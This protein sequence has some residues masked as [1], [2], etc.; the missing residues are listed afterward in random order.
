MLNLSNLFLGRRTILWTLCLLVPLFGCESSL[1]IDFPEHEPELV[2]FSQFESGQPWTVQVLRTVGLDERVAKEN[3][4]VTNA[5]ID[6]FEDGHIVASPVHIGE[7]MYVA[8]GVMPRAG[9]DYT[10]NVSAEGFPLAIATDRIPDRVVEPNIVFSDSAS[11]DP[12][13]NTVQAD[14]DLAF[15]DP[16]DQVNYYFLEAQADFGSGGVPIPYSTTDPVLL[17]TQ[18]GTVFGKDNDDP[19]AFDDATFNGNSFETTIRVQR[20]FANS[21]GVQLVQSTEAYYRYILSLAQIRSA[22][23]NPFSEPVRPVSNVEQGQGIFAGVRRSATVEIALD[24]INVERIAGTYTPF[25]FIYQSVDSSI[26]LTPEQAT[27]DL[28]L[29]P[30]GSVS[31]RIFIQDEFNIQDPGTNLDTT[32]EGSFS[33]DGKRVRMTLS[34]ETFLNEIDWSYERDRMRSEQG[35][36]GSYFLILR[37]VDG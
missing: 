27:L 10:I 4:I 30:D 8:E 36:P 11:I 14:I 18:L 15:S 24:E 19:L 32:L 16:V 31:G 21:Y 13:T 12:E 26:R 28:Q 25:T 35:E 22:E 9:V 34:P 5:R 20:D 7:G 2:L 17:N 6:I 1:D 29:F 3:T 33:Y 37:K 23:D